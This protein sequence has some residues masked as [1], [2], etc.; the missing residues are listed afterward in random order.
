MSISTYSEL[1]TA[2]ANHLHRTD[3]TSVIPTFIQLAEHKIF[4]A[5]DSRK[6]D[7]VVSLTTIAS[8]EYVALPDDFINFRTVA[9]SET[10]Q[11]LKY[12]APEQFAREFLSID[13]GTP[14]NYTI[15]GD[16]MYLSPVPDAVYTLRCVY[17]AKV[18]TL[19]D[20]STTNWL[21]TAYPA[22]YLYGS[23]CEAAP[24]IKDNNQ[25]PIWESLFQRSVESI[26]A[27]DWSS[28]AAMQT[29]G[30]VTV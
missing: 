28:M 26:N 13:S 2:V 18:P 4:G 10:Y 6:Q 11:T 20:S 14:N 15:V 27:Q 30:D 24:Y 22:V 16:K 9:C 5:L 23:L 17:Q 1:Q 29:K 21:L 7:S 25:L 19:S 8:Q 3:L 12:Q